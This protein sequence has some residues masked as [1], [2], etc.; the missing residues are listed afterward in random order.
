MN[1]G[2]SKVMRCLR[3]GNWGRMHVILNGEPL[4]EVDCFK[5][6]GSQV[7]ADGGCERDVHR[8]NEGYR[9]W[10]AL[11]NV[12]S[13]R[14]LGVKAKKCLYVGVI[15]P[16]AVYVAEAWGM[17]RAERRKVKVLEI[18]CLRS[19]V[20]VSRMDRV[21]NEE[22]LRRAGIERE[23]ASRADQ[24]VLRWFGLISMGHVES[25]DGYRTAS[26]VLMAEVSRGR[27]RL[28]SMDGVKVALS[29]KE[30]RWWLRERLESSVAHVTE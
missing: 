6:L 11:K 28:G 22:V 8:M 13:N 20:A 18:K 29:T 19:L 12:L 21:W 16:T 5:F 30:L 10:G 3:Y 2:K 4:E 25:M 23:L 1:L 26:R 17:K 9:A 7:A 24:R 27:P 14:E 15:V